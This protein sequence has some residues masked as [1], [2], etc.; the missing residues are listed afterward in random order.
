MAKLLFSLLYRLLS[1]IRIPRL[2]RRI[3]D[4]ERAEFCRQRAILADG[5]RFGPSAIVHARPDQRDMLRLGTN[6]LVDGELLVHDYGGR[7][8]IGDNTYVGIGSRIWSGE[9]VKVG[10]DVFIAHNVN[11]TDTNSHQVDARER[12]EHYLDHIVNGNPFRKGSIETA[13]VVIGDHAWINF[14]VGILK[15][16]TIGEGAIVGACSLVTKDV[17]PYTLVAGN[18]LREI[19]KLPRPG[20]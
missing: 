8:E 12:H 5:S 3:L 11:I 1:T 17:P 14:N 9:S 16:V 4:E 19:K 15:G 13:P 7:I 20:K 10:N 18:P 2:L 6:T